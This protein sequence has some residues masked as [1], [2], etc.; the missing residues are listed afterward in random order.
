MV[1]QLSTT[2]GEG[3][4][5]LGPPTSDSAPPLSGSVTIGRLLNLLTLFP[6]FQNG[7]NANIYSAFVRIEL[8]FVNLKLILEKLLEHSARCSIEPSVSSCY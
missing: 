8:I 3:E 2:A 7:D 4:P 5:W 6:D 1:W